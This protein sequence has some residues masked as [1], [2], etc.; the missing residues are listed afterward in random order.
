VA[1]T[2]Q[3]G[4]PLAP[5]LPR[6]SDANAAYRAFARQHGIA[7]QAVKLHT[8]ER[9]RHGVHGAIHVQ[10]VNGCCRRLR[11]WLASFRGVASRYL[12]NELGWRRALD[13][14][15][16]RTAEQLLRMA[17]GCIHSSLEQRHE[18]KSRARKRGFFS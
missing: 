15:R 10:N 6:L 4:V 1:W 11:Q 17:S 9:V 14:G 18:K 13:G 2:G 12:P 3:H 8:G 5:P 16:G 7:H